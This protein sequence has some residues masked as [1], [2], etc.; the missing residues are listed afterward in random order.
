MGKMPHWADIVLIPLIS[1]LLAAVLSSLVILAIGENP[2]AAFKLMVDG[3]LMRSAGWGY[4]LYYATNFMF[5]GLAVAVAFHARMFNI[6]GEGQAMLGGLGVAFACLYIPWPHWSIAI[7]GASTAAALFGAFW[8]LIPAYLQAKRGSHIVITTIMFNF[9]AAALLNYFLV[10]VLRPPRSMDPATAKFPEPTH[11]PSFQDMFSTAE[12][13]LFRGA[14]ANVT[15]FIAVAACFL[16]WFLIWRTK[17]GYE[18]RAFG[19]SESGAKYAGISPVRITVIA[20]LISGALAGLMSVNTTMGESERLVLNSTEGA[21]F[22][23]IA[24]ALMGRSHPFGVFLA[25]ILFGFLYQG[26]AELAL[27]TDI[28]RELIVVIQA[29]VILFTGALD[30]MV[31][32]PLEKLFLA[33]RK[34]DA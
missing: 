13:P 24:V 1:L 33:L 7:L 14:P 12:N 22:I 21:G 17:L 15:F 8:A 28:P 25:A 23:G 10:N 27:W 16:V 5:T 6:G 34:G 2:I 9:I 32:M 19:F 30:N 11:L 20:M 3:A 29:L 18:I 4:T 31:R 26:G